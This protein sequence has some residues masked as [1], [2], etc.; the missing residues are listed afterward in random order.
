M[1]IK[2]IANSIRPSKQA[3]QAPA[4]RLV[5]TPTLAQQKHKVQ[6]RKQAA[7]MQQIANSQLAQQGK[8][9]ELDRVKAIMAVGDI[10]HKQRLG[11]I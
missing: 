1:R 9:T 10:E 6:I 11:K 8:V 3:I 4:A 7:L 5:A 2:E